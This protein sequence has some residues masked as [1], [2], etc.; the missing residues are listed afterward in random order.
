MKHYLKPVFALA[1][2][3]V[4]CSTAVQAGSEEKM[5][6]ALKSDHFDISSLLVG[7]SQTIETDSGKIIDVLR[8]ADGIE[9]YVDGELLDIDFN[10]EGLHEDHMV[11]KHVEVI[12]GYDEECDTDLETLHEMH[13]HA[14]AHKI[15]VIEKEVTTKD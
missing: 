9:I 5:V 10:G 3:A 11:G 13:K 8:T 7:E 14:E 12:C 6:I 2:L 15:I 1:A 4:L